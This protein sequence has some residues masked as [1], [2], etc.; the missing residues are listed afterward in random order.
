MSQSTHERVVRNAA[1]IIDC[2]AP[3]R[4][5]HYK[6]VSDSYTLR[7]VWVVMV[8]QVLRKT[9]YTR[10]GFP[11]YKPKKPQ[12]YTVPPPVCEEP[13]PPPRKSQDRP[14]RDAPPKPKKPNTK[15]KPKPEPVREETHTKL[16]EETHEKPLK[17]LGMGGK[18]TVRMEGSGEEQLDFTHEEWLDV[19]EWL[20]GYGKG[21]SQQD[22]R[23]QLLCA[24]EAMNRVQLHYHKSIAA[25]GKEATQAFLRA[26]VRFLLQD[27]EAEEAEM[28]QHLK[29]LTQSMSSQPAVVMHL[30]KLQQYRQCLVRPELPQLRDSDKP[31]VVGHVFGLAGILMDSAKE[32]GPPDEPREAD[33]HSL[34]DEDLK[35]VELEHTE[36]EEPEELEELEELEEEASDGG[37]LETMVETKE[38]APKADAQAEQPEDKAAELGPE[39]KTVSQPLY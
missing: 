2:T 10:G 21:Y 7:L 31:A 36:P 13:D 1:S 23:G 22:F 17:E 18:A 26:A 6:Q 27:P 14:W 28:Q 16:I 25:L 9:R 39:D 33:V 5:M 12:W 29:T 34:L 30:K 32:L 8:A 19:L 4:A 11:R 37:A 35:R 3:K 20:W 15:R 24:A 38:D